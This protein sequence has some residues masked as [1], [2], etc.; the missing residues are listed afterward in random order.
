MPYRKEKNEKT[1][2]SHFPKN[3]LSRT[4][5]PDASHLA[6]TLCTRQD[7]HI[8]SCFFI[9]KSAARERFNLSDA[10]K[11]T[12]V[13]YSFYSHRAVNINN[14]ILTQRKLIWLNVTSLINDWSGLTS[15]EEE[16]V[17]QPLMPCRQTGII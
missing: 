3:K 1:S 6:L 16:G 10:I 14:I 9:L 7:L 11:K 5:T 12:T 2:S 13:G 17:L 15:A 4:K 8:P